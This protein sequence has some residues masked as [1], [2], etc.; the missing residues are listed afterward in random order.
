[1]R[2]YYFSLNGEQQGPFSLSELNDKGIRPETFIWFD[3]LDNWTK[4]IEIEELSQ[5]ISTDRS[6]PISEKTGKIEH[7]TK[8]V[9]QDDQIKGVNVEKT[10]K[11]Q[12]KQNSSVESKE[13][14]PGKKILR[15]LVNLIAIVSTMF[16][17]FL[18]GINQEFH[19]S[20]SNSDLEIRNRDE[21]IHV[22]QN[23][24]ETLLDENIRLSQSI[25]R[26]ERLQLA[27]MRLQKKNDSLVLELQ[28][29]SS[30]NQNQYSNIESN[31]EKDVNAFSPVPGTKYFR[32]TGL[33]RRLRSSASVNSELLYLIPKKSFIVI[34][35]EL[36]NSWCYVAVDGK[37]GYI[38]KDILEPVN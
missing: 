13:K 38:H 12:E 30:Q 2:Q 22:L 15:V 34:L 28:Y 32:A 3:G 25:E 23:Q 21:Q 1:M 18:Y 16:S 36:S 27:N 19:Q 14:G 20:K 10:I 24:S 6:N 8:H 17:I 31:L 37:R 4:A 5:I 11:N 26:M 33:V 7:P 29:F 35:K 9:N